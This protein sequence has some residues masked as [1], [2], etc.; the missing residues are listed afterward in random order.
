MN[1]ILLYAVILL[2]V[3]I[4]QIGVL[5][6]ILGGFPQPQ[7]LLM[8]VLLAA[9]R[10]DESKNQLDLILVLALISGIFLD[11][12]SSYPFGLFTATF[13]IFAAASYFIARVW[14]EAGIN[15]KNISLI[16]FLAAVV[17]PAVLEAS[18]ADAV[19]PLIV[20]RSVFVGAIFLL[21]LSFAYYVR[22]R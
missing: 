22:T 20:L 3:L 21:P 16:L 19:S 11:L 12:L 4:F 14:F 8:A 18:R 7:L 6:P 1:R 5:P 13:L 17:L 2:A 15:L 9:V 10:T